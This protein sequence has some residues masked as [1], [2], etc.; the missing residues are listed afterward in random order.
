VASDAL[1]DELE[2]LV[3]TFRSFVEEHRGEEWAP[4][5][6]KIVRDAENGS[7]KARARR[8]ARRLAQDDESNPAEG[9]A[10]DIADRARTERRTADVLRGVSIFLLVVAT[11]VAAFVLVNLTPDGA[12]TIELARLALTIPLVLLAHYAGHEATRHRAAADA[13]WREEVLLRHFPDFM[14]PL[15]DDAAQAHREDL[16]RRVSALSTTEVAAGDPLTIMGG[17]SSVLEQLNEMI[18]SVTGRG[19]A[20]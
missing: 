11:A 3:A 2:L 19:S 13:L 5:A 16:W 8:A 15:P 18:K 17:M 4:D 7:A 10:V 12:L 9:L 1:L 14:R 6:L 20:G